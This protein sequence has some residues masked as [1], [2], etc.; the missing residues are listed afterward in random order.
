MPTVGTE[1]LGNV[2]LRSFNE[3]IINVFLPELHGGQYFIPI[4]VITNQVSIM[5][6]NIL[7]VSYLEPPLYPDDHG[8]ASEIGTR[9]PGIP[10]LFTEPDDRISRYVLPCIRITPE[11]PSPAN[12]RWNGVHLK[13]MAPAKNAELLEADIGFG[14]VVQGW[15]K[16]QWQQGAKPFDMPYTITAGTA[17][18]AAR[19]NCEIL[20]AYL[21]QIFTPEG[22]LP[23]IDTIGNTRYYNF[24]TEGP[25]SLSMI[26]DISDRGIM[27]SL[28]VRVLGELDVYNP[29]QT[30]GGIVTQKVVSFHQNGG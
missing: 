4:D 21:L 6:G 17:G 10:L 2:F 7:D 1:I 3:G 26:A 16:R 8:I 23:V 14:N 11:D 12:E 15:S 18:N 22:S 25:S 24:F 27:Q 19:L 29:E 30:P 9:M 28:S 5:F 13:Y 20:L